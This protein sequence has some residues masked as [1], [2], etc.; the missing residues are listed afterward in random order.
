M[1]ER[2]KNAALGGEGKGGEEMQELENGRMPIETSF[3]LECM[4]HAA[5]MMLH[6]GDMLV[7]NEKIRV[8]IERDPET[9]YCSMKRETLF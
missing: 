7:S 4:D 8:T 6:L 2:V 9:G 1:R 3:K 5:A